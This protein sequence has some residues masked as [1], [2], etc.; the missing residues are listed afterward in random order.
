VAWLRWSI[1]FGLPANRE[2]SDF[3]LASRRR[4]RSRL[5]NGRPWKRVL[6]RPQPLQDG[7]LLSLVELQMTAVEGVQLLLAQRRP[8]QPVGPMAGANQQVPQL[9]R[10]RVTR[11][12]I[13]PRDGIESVNSRIAQ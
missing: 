8:H 10:H 13:G 1:P 2:L 11:Q 6:P 3:P 4:R 12:L 5:S 9:M 7:R